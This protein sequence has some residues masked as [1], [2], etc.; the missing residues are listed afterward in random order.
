MHRQDTAIDGKTYFDGV[1]GPV[2][3]SPVIEV[4][5]KQPEFVRL[6]RIKQLGCADY[7]YSTAVGNRYQHSIGTAILTRRFLTN[8]LLREEKTRKL[9]EIDEKDIIC[10][11]IAA[12]CHDLGHALLSHFYDGRFI[13]EK[14]PM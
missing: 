14:L 2:K 1:Y 3:L 10:V 12:L 7:V 4:I 9:H 5:R 11:E 6:R 8:F 13:K